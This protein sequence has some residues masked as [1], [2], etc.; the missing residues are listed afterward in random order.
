M[1]ADIDDCEGVVCQNGGTCE[2]G[3][4]YFNCACVAGYSGE[5]CETSE[6]LAL[7]VCAP[8][9]VRSSAC[10][11]PHP[12]AGPVRCACRHR[13]MRGRHVPERRH[14]HGRRERLHVR[15]RRGLHRGELRNE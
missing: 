9:G 8:L 6:W 11:T 10:L 7:G 4:N 13:R 1:L 14:V 12:L 15:V 2:D 3:V 5:N